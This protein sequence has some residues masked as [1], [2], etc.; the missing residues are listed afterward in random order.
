[1]PVQVN[2]RLVKQETMKERV[3]S[4]G[5]Y[6]KPI[7]GLSWSYFSPFSCPHGLHLQSRSKPVKY[8][9]MFS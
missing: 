7:Y 8:E 6:L 3:G 5:N 4:R 1:M 9:L 2:S